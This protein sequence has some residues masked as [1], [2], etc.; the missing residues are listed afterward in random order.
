MV[1][2][3]CGLFLRAPDGFAKAARPRDVPQLRSKHAVD[4]DAPAP[5]HTSA[6][7]AIEAIMTLTPPRQ[8]SLPGN[9]TWAVLLAVVVL[10]IALVFL[11][12]TSSGG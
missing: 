10:V 3:T 1:Q 6:Q 9:R 8:P 5:V 12:L 7:V 2:E 11:I 4:S